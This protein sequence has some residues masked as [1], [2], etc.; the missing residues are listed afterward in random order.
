MLV[1]KPTFRI[2][3]TAKTSEYWVSFITR[4]LGFPLFLM[5]RAVCRFAVHF[6]YSLEA[7]IHLFDQRTQAPTPNYS[8]PIR[9]ILKNFILQSSKDMFLLICLLITLP[10]AIQAC[11]VSQKLCFLHAIQA[12][13]CTNKPFKN[14]KYLHLRKSVD[15]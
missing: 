2:S 7:Q 14:E 12:V 6:N 11:V 13:L 5:H 1:A 10:G 9:P 3:S 4:K 8:T 15:D